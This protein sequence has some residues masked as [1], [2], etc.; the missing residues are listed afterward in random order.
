MERDRCIK[1]VKAAEKKEE[2]RKVA[3][4]RI[5]AMENFSVLPEPQIFPAA[6]AGGKNGRARAR[7]TGMKVEDPREDPSSV[8]DITTR[9][10]SPPLDHSPF[11]LFDE[12]E[13]ERPKVRLPRVK[14]PR[15]WEQRMIAKS[16]EELEEET[17]RKMEE[18]EEWKAYQAAMDEQATLNW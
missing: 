3:M 17:Y 14:S 6:Q 13:D 2:E 8:T 4:E 9:C 1:R 16:R 12:E 18:S 11:T 5:V 15:P 7:I 10:E